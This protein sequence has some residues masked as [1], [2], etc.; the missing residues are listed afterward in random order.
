MLGH[1]PLEE[2]LVFSKKSNIPPKYTS[3][4][5]QICDWSV[6]F[7]KQAGCDFAFPKGKQLS[8]IEQY[9]HLKGI[10]L[11]HPKEL[12]CEL[13]TTQMEAIENFLENRVSIIQVIIIVCVRDSG[14]P[15]VWENII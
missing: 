4:A 14:C 8:P 15:S 2:E 11:E 3:D 10:A 12:P 7:K 1:V 9:K 13:D 6:I 5:A